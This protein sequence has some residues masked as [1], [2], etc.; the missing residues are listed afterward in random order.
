MGMFSNQ[1][2]KIIE[3]ITSDVKNESESKEFAV[4]LRILTFILSL[5]YVLTSVFIASQ[6]HYFLGLLLIF[7]IGFLAA[8]FICTYENK[9]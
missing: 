1:K 3:F 2:R 8:S 6:G 9:T 4:L 7:T 5:Y